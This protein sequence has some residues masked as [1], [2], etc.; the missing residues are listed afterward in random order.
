MTEFSD[1]NRITLLQNGAEYFPA[2]EASLDA[3]KREVHLETYIFEND[4][5]GRKIAAA[6]ARAARRGVSTH[7]MVDGFGSQDLGRAL[8]DE[9]Q[10]A[11]VHFLVYRPQI[12]PWSFQRA[13]L[14][15]LHRKVV[16]IDARVAYVGGINILDDEDAR[17]GIPARFD[18]AV[19]VEGPLVGS[20]YPP[21]KRLW[22]LVAATQLRSRRAET[23]ALEPGEMH[24]GHQRAAFVLRDNLGHRR[25]I[26]EAYLE[27]IEGSRSEIL[28]AN[29]YFF[30]G[31]SFRSALTD[32]A[33]RG[34]RVRLL[35]QGRPEY[36]LLYYASRALYG[37]FLDAGVEIYEY[38]RS[39]LHAKVA[40]I[41]RRWS[42]VGSSNI[43]PFSLLL[44]RE[45]N[46]VIDDRTFAEELH[47]S[48]TRAID[49][50]ATQLPLERWSHQPLPMRIAT[51]VCYG[52][53]RLLM[54][55]SAYAR[56]EEFA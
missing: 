5:T 6:L 13:R 11:G 34:V 14:R 3:A 16:V 2:L 9:M 17:H 10:A 41:D 51:W 21:V 46:V 18:S 53:T 48:L 8:A 32:A 15:R 27:A 52:V 45:A 38:H 35:L 28:L 36:L 43:D 39:F 22:K 19:R 20:I 25:E 31:L 54:G 29:A 55:S 4:D 23:H 40:V 47:A 56:T 26:E 42:T 30:P 1:G 37:P 7:V 24:R 44:A 33:R 50:G 12:S 49:Q